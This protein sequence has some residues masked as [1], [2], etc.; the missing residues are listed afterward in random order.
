M[1][2]LQARAQ[3]EVEELRPADEVVV[4]AALVAVLEQLEA[5]EG[6]HQ[7]LVAW[8]GDR[9]SGSRQR[10]TGLVDRL[11]TGGMAKHPA[12]DETR[13]PTGMGL[14]PAHLVAVAPRDLA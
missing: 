7:R 9:G 3:A 13:G 10:G 5:Q 8:Q 2:Q 14:E 11:D 12:L 1:A 6:Q 4:E